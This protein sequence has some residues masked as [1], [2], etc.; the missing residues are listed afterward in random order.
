MRI[1]VTLLALAATTAVADTMQEHV[2]TMSSG[3]MPF[4]MS[5]T[6]HIFAMNDQ[7]GVQKVIV[8]SGADP[9][10]I[11][12][13]RQHLR[14]EAEAFAKGDFGDPGHLHGDSMPGLSDMK[15]NTTRIHVSFAPL[16]DGAQIT[17]QATDLHAITAIHRW[18]GAQLSEHGADARAE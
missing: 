12:L 2:H 18:F 3:V 17:F 9:A 8:R 11:G 6:M 1:V 7:G 10:Q 4:D 15:A 5:Q 13:V 16:P 14:H